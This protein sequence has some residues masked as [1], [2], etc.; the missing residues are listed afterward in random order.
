MKSKFKTEVIGSG[1]LE[2]QRDWQKIAG[3][4]RVLQEWNL[5]IGKDQLLKYTGDVVD[6]GGIRK[7]RRS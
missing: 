2:G 3:K 6:G 5:D 7:S 4:Y 1:I